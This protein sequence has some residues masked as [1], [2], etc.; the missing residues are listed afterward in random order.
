MQIVFQGTGLK[1]AEDFVGWARDER[2]K[3]V[4]L[5]CIEGLMCSGKSRLLKQLGSCFCALDLDCYLPK[6]A[7]VEVEWVAQVRQ[8]GAVAGIQ[9]AMATNDCV[10]V[11]GAVGWPV[12]E[13][14]AAE[15]K[16]NA[17]RR[18]YIKALSTRGDPPMW[19]EYDHLQRR[20]RP[21]LYT[22]SIDEY[23]RVSEPWGLA[24]L[25]LERLLD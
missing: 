12:V 14:I 8:G 7:S 9:Q 11:A 6:N 16:V 13:P 2:A 25:V 3:G 17:V 15:L 23:H 24:D 18:V 4:R 5:I 1:I 10:V 22:R 19:D 20:Q 21:T